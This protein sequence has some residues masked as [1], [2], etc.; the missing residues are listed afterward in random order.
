MRDRR[1]RA[2][3]TFAV[4]KGNDEDLLG[5]EESEHMRTFRQRKGLLILVAYVLPFMIAPKVP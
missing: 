5:H 1:R 4:V 3:V 2:G